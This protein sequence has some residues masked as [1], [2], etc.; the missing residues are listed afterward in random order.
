MPN[1]PAGSGN[2]PLSLPPPSVSK[3][4]GNPLGISPGITNIPGP[5]GG[6][7]LP[8][9][10]DFN[11]I[12]G[13]NPTHIRYEKRAIQDFFTPLFQYVAKTLG[14]PVRD[15][16]FLQISSDRVKAEFRNRPDLERLKPSLISKA[17][18][19]KLKF[20]SGDVDTERIVNQ[21]LANAAINGWTDV[22]VL[23]FWN[24]IPSG[25]G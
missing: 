21:F 17:N 18:Q 4:G 14:W 10:L 11:Q 7:I 25:G 5:E 22:M 15:N 1:P 12:F 8:F 20:I 23:T 24:A 9:E 3:V 2:P 16:H 19:I 13:L 6:I